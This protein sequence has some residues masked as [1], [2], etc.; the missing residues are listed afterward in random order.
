MGHGFSREGWISRLDLEQQDV[1]PPHIVLHV[2]E[3][4]DGRMS[5]C[6]CLLWLPMAV[7]GV[8]RGLQDTR[9]P[10]YATL[11]ANVLNVV[12]G[13]L[14]IFGLGLGVRGAALGTVCAQ[15]GG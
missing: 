3:V 9:T 5:C 1:H 12:L 4:P 7:Q 8:Y 2:D 13:W 11:A 14:F 6:C 15:V 10:F